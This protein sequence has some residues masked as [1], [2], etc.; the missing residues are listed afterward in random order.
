[1]N[2]HGL[3]GDGGYGGGYGGGAGS[4][5]N[6]IFSDLRILFLRDCLVDLKNQGKNLQNFGNTEID[7]SKWLSYLS[8]I[9][10]IDITFCIFCC[11]SNWMIF[12][13]IDNK[14]KSN[15][16]GIKQVLRTSIS[17]RK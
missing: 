10:S 3:G 11:C 7:I 12:G 17:D 14:V 16:F 5:W 1:M 15:E 6:K 2:M 4:F 9:Y 8:E 13:I